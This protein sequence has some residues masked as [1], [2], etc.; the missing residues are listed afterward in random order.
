MITIRIFLIFAVYSKNEVIEI[1]IEKI[2]NTT[3]K[4]IFENFSKQKTKHFI[5]SMIYLIIE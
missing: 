4:K 1:F 5:F 2:E 3:M